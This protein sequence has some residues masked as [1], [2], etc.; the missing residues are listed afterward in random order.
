MNPVFIVL[1]LLCAVCVWAILSIVFQPLGNII[2]KIINK[3]SN[4]LEINNEK[5]N[6]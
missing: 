6:N 1:V 5:E 4:K 3:I 2:N